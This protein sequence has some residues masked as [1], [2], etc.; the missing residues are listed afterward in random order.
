MAEDARNLGFTLSSW[1]R[2]EAKRCSLPVQNPIVNHDAPIGAVQDIL[3]LSPYLVVLTCDTDMLHILRWTDLI[4]YRGADG[5][6]GWTEE[7][8]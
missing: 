1:R 8:G 2:G 5:A 6:F 4:K 3:S 7:E